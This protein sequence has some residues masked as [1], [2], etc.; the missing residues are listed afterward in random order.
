MV[1]PAIC[2]MKAESGKANDLEVST[3]VQD[4]KISFFHLENGVA[5]K[6]EKV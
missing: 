4:A 6:L 3:P 2:D 5:I 1:E